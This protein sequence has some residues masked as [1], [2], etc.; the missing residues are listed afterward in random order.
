MKSRHA[1]S[2]SAF[3]FFL[4]IPFS[5]I[6]QDSAP[7]EPPSNFLF[8]DKFYLTPSQ[9]IRY[10]TVPAEGLLVLEQPAPEWN[11]KVALVS[12]F[13]PKA[14]R[15]RAL[16][17][18][19]SVDEAKAWIGSQKKELSYQGIPIVELSLPSPD[20]RAE[21]RYWVG[22]K[23][24][25]SFEEASREIA[26]VESLI[27][28]QGGNFSRARELAREFKEA[29]R[30]PPVERVKTRAQFQKEE[31]IAL[32]WL[33][34]LDIP[35][36][37]YGPFQGVGAGEPTLWQS[38]GESTWR[39]TNLGERKFNS[40]VGFWTQRLVFKGIRFP[41][42]TIDPYVELTGALESSPNDGGSQ[43]DTSIGIEWRPLQ[44]SSF[45][46]NFRPGGIPLLAFAKNY[47]FLMQYMN[48]RNLKD[49]IANIHH[50]DFRVG[51]AIFY[52]WG[53]DLPPADQQPE[54]GFVGWLTDYVWGE[55]FGDYTWRHTNFTV[56]ESYNAWTLDTSVILGIKT[57]ALDLPSNPINSNLILMP[58]FRFGLIANDEF[59]NPPD[60]RYFVAVGLRWMPFRDYRFANNEWLFKTKFFVE[61]LGI[62]KVQNLKQD[63][64]RPHPDEDWR[65]GVAWSLRRF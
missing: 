62:G 20:G 30:V 31:E 43:L 36:K 50:D 15:T 64:S 32:R 38:F 56:H 53:I 33:D 65:I 44:R 13:A 21:P 17:G 12:D 34:Q 49:E 26:M 2:A 40:L 57:P 63:D 8:R 19:Q 60:N 47:R 24:F 18:I 42:S 55:Y 37:L 6:A 59:S 10:Q 58:Y 45:L 16:K 22:N 35:E 14:L 52:E 23:S 25:G 51:F 7:P 1:F 41:I 46:D 48:R 54:R 28:A 27:Q 5:L 3:L 9:K 4:F 11:S 29:E 39:S 61:W